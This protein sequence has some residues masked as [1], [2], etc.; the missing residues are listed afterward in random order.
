[1]NHKKFKPNQLISTKY[2]Q[3]S[4]RQKLIQIRNEYR[5]SYIQNTCN[6]MNRLPIA[7]RPARLT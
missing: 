3:R 6:G 7:I 4:K 5:Q 1:M 2:T